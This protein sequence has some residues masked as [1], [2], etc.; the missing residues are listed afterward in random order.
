MADN[1]TPATRVEKLL[2]NPGSLTPVTRI[3]KFIQRSGGGG[4]GGM[5]N[6][7]KQALLDCFEHVVWIDDDGQEYV[8][9]LEEAMYPVSPVPD[10]LSISA[11]YTQSGT[12]YDTDSLDSLKADLVVTAN[13]DDGTSATVTDYTLSGTLVEGTST[14]T[15]SY[16]GQTD[17]F[18]V[19][20]THAP[21]SHT[22]TL[23]SIIDSSLDGHFFNGNGLPNQNREGYHV[24]IYVEIAE[25]TSITFSNRLTYKDLA[26]CDL[27]WYNSSKEILSTVNIT[28]TSWETFEAPT[29]A[30]YFRVAFAEQDLNYTVTYY[31]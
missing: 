2:N 10:L 30:V 16:E 18:N 13:Y 28:T 11:V 15:V 23:Q 8:D 22:V 31:Y 21:A 17:T 5:S 26:S 12:V 3:E 9:A 24:S 20:V 25:G 4:S 27:V 14:I 1:L 6:A 7:V 29:N 19:V